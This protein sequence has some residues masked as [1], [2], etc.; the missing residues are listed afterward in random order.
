MNNPRRQLSAN[1]LLFSYENLPHSQMCVLEGFEVLGIADE[2]M[3][4]HFA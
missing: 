1:L 4:L 3:Y 2:S